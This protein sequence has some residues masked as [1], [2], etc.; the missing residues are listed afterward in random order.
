MDAASGPEQVI[1]EKALETGSRSLGANAWRDLRRRPMFWISLALIVVFV[2]MAIFPQLFTSKDPTYADLTKARQAP[3]TEAV[4]RYDTQGYDV[5]ARTVY[6]ARAS[7]IVGILATAFTLV[8]GSAV[9]IIA[10][11]RGGWLDSVLRRFGEIFL[12]HPAAARRDLVPLHL[13][14]P[15]R[16]PFA[17]AV[18]KVALVSRILGWPTIT[19]LMRSSVLQ[20]KP[21][22]YVQ[23][24]RALGA[25]PRRIITSHIL[26]NSLA[27]VI[28]VSTI[29][30]GVFISVEATLSFLGIGLQP[31]V[32]SWGNMISEASG[33]G[34]IRAAPHMLLF[35]EPVPV[36]DCA[37]L[38]HARRRRP[39]RPRSETALRRTVVTL[40][41]GT[42][43]KADVEVL[44][45][46][47]VWQPIDGL[48][49]EVDR[50]AGG[51]PHPRRRRQGHQWR[52]VR[53]P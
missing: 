15:G 18:G 44:D 27:S 23:A 10:G 31:P 6:G 51:V 30:L 12:A 53:P 49:L 46:S 34:L 22:D 21:N 17:V 7:I 11:Y 24:A 41:V 8:F 29:N 16:H 50:S 45:T 32:I 2:L 19:R 48:L 39:R 14:Q 3:S 4:V 36:A 37:G 33:I 43:G 35:P 25:S 52:L 38:H 47:G 1:S 42:S 40:S 28:V 13:P 26:P 20:V 5:Y 9:G